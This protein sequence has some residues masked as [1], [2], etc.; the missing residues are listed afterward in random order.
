MAWI[1]QSRWVGSVSAN[2]LSTAVARRD[3]NRGLRGMLGHFIV[4]PVLIV[5]AVGNDGAKLR[6]LTSSSPCSGASGSGGDGRHCICAAWSG[7]AI[8]KE[9]AFYPILSAWATAASLH[10]SSS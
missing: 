2:G 5:G 9:L 8:R 6:R 7:G 10:Q 4:N 1:W 3:D